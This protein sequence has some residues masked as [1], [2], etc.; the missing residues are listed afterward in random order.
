MNEHPNETKLTEMHKIVREELTY[1][2][3][4]QQQIFTWSSAILVA[5]I[6]AMLVSNPDSLVMTCQGKSLAIVLAM[7]ISLASAYWQMKQRLLLSSLQKVISRIM[8]EL[9]LSLIHI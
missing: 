6:A 8:T 3:S 5:I 4:R 7:G 9:G 1:R 2:R